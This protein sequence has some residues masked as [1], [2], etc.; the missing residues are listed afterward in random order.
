MRKLDHGEQQMNEMFSL[1][2]KNKLIFQEMISLIKKYNLIFHAWLW[3]AGYLVAPVK[4]DTKYAF[5]HTVV[6]HG[7]CEEGHGKYSHLAH[8]TCVSAI[9][10][11]RKKFMK[12]SKQRSICDL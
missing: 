11:I 10:I 3:Y 6:R 7:K 5:P 9:V 1:I 4:W 2:K 8:N 12:V